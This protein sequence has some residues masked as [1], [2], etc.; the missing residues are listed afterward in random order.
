MIA[1]DK[2]TQKKYEILE[3]AQKR[4]EIWTEDG[5]FWARIREKH[6]RSLS[7]PEACD[8]HGL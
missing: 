2:N 4:G 8:I 1:K 3:N 7:L 5:S 6:L